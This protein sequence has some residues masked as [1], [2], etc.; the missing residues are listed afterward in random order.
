[1]LEC[2]EDVSV[3]ILDSL[4]LCLARGHIVVQSWRS[5]ELDDGDMFVLIERESEVI[6]EYIDSCK[7][8]PESLCRFSSK[9]DKIWMYLLGDIKGLSSGREIGIVEEC[10]DFVFFGDRIECISATL[11]VMRD[12]II[13]SDQGDISPDHTESRF[14]L[15]KETR[16]ARYTITMYPKWAALIRHMDFRVEYDDPIVTARVPLLES[17]HRHRVKSSLNQRDELIRSINPIHIT[18]ERSRVGLEDKRVSILLSDRHDL[19]ITP[20]LRR[21]R[22]IIW[23]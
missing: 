9:I 15:L 20:C 16:N 8:E 23:P 14:F 4:S 10:H 18:P 2:S 22:C 5:I 3:E 7:S 12:A 1:M 13:Q 11:E 19:R 6:G 17:E 21:M